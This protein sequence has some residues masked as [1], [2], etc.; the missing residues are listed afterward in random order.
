MTRWWGLGSTVRTA[1]WLM[2]AWVASADSAWPA[3]FVP[4]DDAQILERLPTAPLNHTRRELKA[5]RADWSQHPLDEHA[6]ATLARRYITLA[7]EDGDPRHLGHA[8]AVLAPWWDMPQSSPA[9]LVLQATI[10]QSLHDFPGA[11]RDVDLALSRQPNQTQA[12]LTR[13]AILRVQ[14]RYDEA[15]QACRALYRSASTLL[16]TTCLS[17]VSS[18]TGQ[19]RQSYQL[20]DRM[21]ALAD[22]TPEE[23]EW[24]LITLAEMAERLGDFEAAERHF[25]EAIR[26]GA[27]HQYLLGA[28]ADLLLDRGRPEDARR[29]L[30]RHSTGTRSDV[31]LLRAALAQ[32][33]LGSPKA[34]ELIALLDARFAASRQR[35]DR[36]H[37]RE[38]AR[39]LLTLLKQPQAA[40]ELAQANWAVQREPQDARV[41]LE[42]ALAARDPAAAA[43]VRAWMRTTKVEDVTLTALATQLDALQR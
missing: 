36:L 15:R 12:L 10:K 35:G 24:V 14:A 8:Q 25:Q 30:D 28:Y 34:N 17:D 6:A 7:R 13:A 23:R 18:L 2:A 1:L 21:L 3:P 27:T 40:C 33:A 4:A 38:E 42:A 29:L 5:L 39:F 43:P 41:L 20:L 37:L 16:A 9:L 31:S 22:P 26:S 19:A 32:Q 11:L